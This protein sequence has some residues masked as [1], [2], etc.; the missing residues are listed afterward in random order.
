MPYKTV[1]E[2][3]DA[4]RGLPDH[5][6]EIYLAAFNAAW[7]EYKDRGN[8]REVLC[9]QVAWAAVKSKYKKEGDKWIAKESKAMLQ[10]KYSEI[11]T[12]Y[13]RRNAVSD[14]A[15]IHKILE[16][17]QEL[18]DPIEEELDAE[19][20]KKV[21]EAIKEADSCL[22]WLKEQKVMKTEDGVQFP[23]EAFAYV[24]DPEKSSEWK[25]RLWESLERG[26]TKVQ[27]KKVAAYLSEGGYAGQ[28]IMIPKE[29]LPAVKR[30]I[31][32]EYR[33]LDVKDEDIPKWVKETEMRTLVIGNALLQEVT[34]KG[35]AKIIIIS[36]GFN[37]SKDRYY[38][39]EML[40]RDFAVFEGVKMYADHPT[41]EEDKL[42]PE[43]SIRDWVATLKNVHVNEK[44]EVIGEAVVIEP[45]MQAKLASLRDKNMLS[46]MG[47]SINAIGTATKGEIEGIK[48]NIIE[49]MVRARSVDFVTEPG[50]GGMVQMYEVDRENDIDLVNLEVLRERRPDLIKLV[51]AEVKAVIQKEVQ[52]TMELT[53]KV[54]ELE[55]NILTLTTERDELK[56]KI[57]EAEKAQKIAEAKSKIDEAI[58]KSEL[59]EAAKRRL[60]EKFANAETADGIT[61]AIKAEADYVNALKESGK[62]KDMGASKPDPEKTHKELV[63]SFK[64]LGMTDEQATTAAKGR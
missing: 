11:I 22:M 6:K 16:L 61:E 45:W 42:R 51:E 19:K 54:K 28:H 43:R 30:K 12:E 2:L 5:A 60:A 49:Q 17:C 3:P 44:G 56:T 33:K 64:R 27:L 15:R 47:I 7:D 29:S 55:A 8:Q 4:I 21:A 35:I 50:A 13:G 59:P 40:A 34:A 24:P 14:A 62:V 39:A 37:S 20:A 18:L 36:P 46:E 58:G 32:A 26:I 38:P 57:T 10:K 48:T 53:E 1:S 25:L 31:R 63:E 52:R 23:S 41:S 9:H